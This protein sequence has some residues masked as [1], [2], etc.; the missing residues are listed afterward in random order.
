MTTTLPHQQSNSAPTITKAGE[1]RPMI[2]APFVVKNLFKPGE[3]AMIAGWRPASE[4]RQSPP[5]SLRTL[6]KDATSGVSPSG[7][8][9]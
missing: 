2:N 3:V 6:L 5:Q 9:W 1:F 7:T 8:Q 4:N